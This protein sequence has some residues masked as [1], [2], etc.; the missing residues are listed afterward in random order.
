MSAWF[1]IEM[2]CAECGMTPLALPRGTY[3]SEDEARAASG[4]DGR[5]L[6]HPDGGSFIQQGDGGFWCA[7]LSALDTTGTGFG[8][9]YDERWSH[10]S[11]RQA[12]TSSG[13]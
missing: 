7:P 10:T 9:E 1:L 13:S 5:W 12:D 3:P 8:D 2:G 11:P 4:R 6:P